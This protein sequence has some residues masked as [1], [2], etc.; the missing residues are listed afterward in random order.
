MWSEVW[1]MIM[2]FRG[3]TGGGK[4]CFGFAEFIAATAV[5]LYWVDFRLQKSGFN[6]RNVCVHI[7]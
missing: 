3:G 7:F 6:E 1:I 5:L 4:L 2:M